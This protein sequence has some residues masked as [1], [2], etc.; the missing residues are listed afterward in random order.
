[1]AVYCGID[2]A[3]GHHDIA[4]VDDEGRLIGKRRIAETLDE[5][6]EL[7]A[8]GCVNLK[9]P[10]DGGARWPQLSCDVDRDADWSSFRPRVSLW[11]RR[12]GGS[13]PVD[14]TRD[15]WAPRRRRG[16]VAA[17]GRRRRLGVR[18]WVCG[19][20]GGAGKAVSGRRG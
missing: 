4:L 17:I 14:R 7:A 2:W 19:C 5:V 13:V 16:L 9:W 15:D 11:R 12:V 1:V 10:R 20:L 3:E 8:I 6:A 18:R